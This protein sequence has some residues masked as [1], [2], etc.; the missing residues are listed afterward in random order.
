MLESV[1]GIFFLMHFFFDAYARP[2]GG[3]VGSPQT[4]I[5]YIYIYTIIYRSFHAH[6]MPLF[7]HFSNPQQLGSLW[8]SS[9]RCCKRLSGLR[10]ARRTPPAARR[11][12]G[13][14]RRDG[15]RLLLQPDDI[16]STRANIYY[17]ILY[18]SLYLII[19]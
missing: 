9:P 16:D 7:L 4:W 12:Y 14:R 8:I 15:L 5:I 1:R 11:G 6:N 13:R 2:Q 19:I 17:M 18:V 10:G 3:M